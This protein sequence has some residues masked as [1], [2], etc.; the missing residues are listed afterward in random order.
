LKLHN[1][2]RAIFILDELKEMTE[3]HNDARFEYVVSRIVWSLC[4]HESRRFKG[5]SGAYAGTQESRSDS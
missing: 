1:E 2:E 3:F 5:G 4:C